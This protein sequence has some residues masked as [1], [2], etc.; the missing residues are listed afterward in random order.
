MASVTFEEIAKFA[1]ELD[2]LTKRNRLG[3][4]ISAGRYVASGRMQDIQQ[5]IRL[6]HYGDKL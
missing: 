6:R 5:E 1:K 3:A 4:L 2:Q